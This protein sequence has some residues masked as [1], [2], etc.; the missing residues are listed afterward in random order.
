MD[1]TRDDASTLDFRSYPILLGLAGT[2]IALDQWTK[3]LVRSRLAYGEVWAPV[4]S[5]AEVVRIVHWSNTGAAFGLLP[6][7]GLFFTL[8]AILVSV[9]IL[10]YYPRIPGQQA[11]LRIALSF[12]LGGAVGNLI[13]RLTQGPVTDMIAVGQFPVFNLAD[14]S[15]S[16]GVALLVL[17]MWREEREER[18]ARVSAD[19]PTRRLAPSTDSEHTLD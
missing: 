11:A 9:A 16:M 1:S 17:A 15:I 5:L 14:T 12:Q 8:V 2:V 4:E 13:D 18:R 3:Y 10:Y 6:N 19:E 7:G